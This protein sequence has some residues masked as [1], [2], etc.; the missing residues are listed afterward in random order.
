MATIS[1]RKIDDV[2]V[3][4]L[5]YMAKEAGFKGL[6]P[7]LR[8][9][10]TQKSNIVM[11]ECYADITASMDKIWADREPLPTGT[12][13]QWIREDRDLTRLAMIFA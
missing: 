12:V 1:I 4:R 9:S 8:D 2:V 13:A 5:Q 7:Y 6:E 10:L 11:Q 3:T